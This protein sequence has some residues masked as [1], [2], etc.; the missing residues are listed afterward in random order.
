MIC[1]TVKHLILAPLAL[2]TACSTLPEGNTLPEELKPSTGDQCALGIQ[3]KWHQ[4][5]DRYYDAIEDINPSYVRQDVFVYDDPDRFAPLLEFSEAS[6]ATLILTVKIEE[7]GE[8]PIGIGKQPSTE[9]LQRLIDL[10]KFRRDTYSDA[11]VIWELGNEPW[12]FYDDAEE[13][14]YEWATL[15]SDTIKAIDPTATVAGPGAQN[16]D[17]QNLKDFLQDTD[18]SDHIDVLTVHN[19]HNRFGREDGQEEFDDLNRWRG[20]IPYLVSEGGPDDRDVPLNEFLNET[21]RAIHEN[22]GKGFIFYELED[23]GTSPY[24]LMETDGSLTDSYEVFKSNLD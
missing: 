10:V 18:Y 7:G 6:N 1:K 9:D 16:L 3:M 2:L 15:V 8:V 19:Y 17:N 22:G 23:S 14:Y 21:R 12:L 24:Y 11:A 4:V 13:F 5:S 20:D